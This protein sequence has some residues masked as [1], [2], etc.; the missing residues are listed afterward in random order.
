MR[1]VMVQFGPYTD[2]RQREAILAA[3]DGWPGVQT[4]CCLKA[5]S[6]S[7]AVRRLGSVALKQDTDEIEIVAALRNLSG[8]ASAAV[9][10]ERIPIWC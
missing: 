7:A 10:R 6:R 2:E 1:H 3:V 8:V 9:E 5:D 4:A